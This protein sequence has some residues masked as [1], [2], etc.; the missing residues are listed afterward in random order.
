MLGGARCNTLSN[1]S[2]PCSGAVVSILHWHIVKHLPKEAQLMR[3]SDF[4]SC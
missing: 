3:A 4:H 2:K 1:S